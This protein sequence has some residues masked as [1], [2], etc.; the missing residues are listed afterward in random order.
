MQTSA[1]KYVQVFD[2]RPAKALSFIKVRTLYEDMRERLSLQIVNG[3]FSFERK[4]REKE[5][6]RPGLAFAGF[7]DVF[8]YW[9][10]QVMGNTEISYL[11]TLTR[12]GR[13]KAIT[14]VLG[15]ELPCII[16][17]S[18]N[19][20]PEELIE[21][22]THHG[23]TVFL[24]PFNT[25]SVHR[26]LSEYLEAKFAP[27]LVVHGTLVDLFSV[28]VL[29]VGQAAIGK[30]E[31]A[32]DLIERGHQLVAD[33]AVEITKVGSNVLQGAPRGSIGHHMEIRGLGIIDIFKM[34]G[35]RG[36]RGKKDIHVI[37]KLERFQQGKSYERTG[38]DR[39]Y[40]KIMGV[41]IPLVELPVLEGKN[42]TIVAE[43]VAL[44]H[45][46]RQIG[47]DQAQ[48]FDERLKSILM[49]P[50]EETEQVNVDLEE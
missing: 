17:T 29:F 6:N 27:R 38:L 7:V 32:L 25:T 18:N 3:D 47:I 24:T 42:L 10:V 45:K 49:A 33:D 8:T 41:E 34:F 15:F 9:R 14:T 21:I 35:V 5:L 28:G 50:E 1:K 19:P 13:I 43:A 46:L 23:I 4:I 39:V 44:N 2:P 11:S 37:V 48:E 20:V 36:I 40:T 26:H 12:E 31:L 22:A 30:S 16:I